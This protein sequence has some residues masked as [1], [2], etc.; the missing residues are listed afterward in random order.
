MCFCYFITGFLSLPFFAFSSIVC[1]CV[2]VIIVFTVLLLLLKL[3]YLLQHLFVCIFVYVVCFAYSVLYCSILFSH[4]VYLSACL[5]VCLLYHKA[6]NW[7][8][9]FL[10]NEFIKWNL[11]LSLSTQS[12]VYI[13]VAIRQNIFFKSLKAGKH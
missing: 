3:L 9:I 2:S 1:V 11:L 8:T 13:S 12:V 5:L 10:E 7:I 4:F 6:V